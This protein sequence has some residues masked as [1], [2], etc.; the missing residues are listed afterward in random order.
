[1]R[2]G[3][4][5]HLR[6]RVVG[7]NVRERGGGSERKRAGWRERTQE[8]GVVGANARERRGAGANVRE[9]RKGA[10]VRERG[11]G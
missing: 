8:S 9:R 4:R 6:A 11:A 3:A 7:A 2:E 10:N 1:M 5:S